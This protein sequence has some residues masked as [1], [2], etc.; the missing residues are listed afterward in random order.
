MKPWKVFILKNAKPYNIRGFIKDAI[1]SGYNAT[2]PGSGKPKRIDENNTKVE[3][4][5]YM[6]GVSALI[7][8]AEEYRFGP[9]NDGSL[10]IEEIVASLD[11]PDFKG[12]AGN[13]L[14]MYFPA[15]RT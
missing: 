15:Y 7:V 14:V 8:S 3:V 4:I 11:L 5:Q 1:G 2:T 9:Q 6:D 10:G 13:S 12:G